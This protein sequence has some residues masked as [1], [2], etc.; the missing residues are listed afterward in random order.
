ATNPPRKD[1]RATSTLTGPMG[2]AA[3]RPRSSPETKMGGCESRMANR[4]RPD[5]FAP[6]RTRQTL[7]M[8][9][10]SLEQAVLVAQDQ[11][12]DMDDVR[13]WAKA[14]LNEQKFSVFRRRLN[15]QR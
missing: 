14:E 9:L 15:R 11:D 12:I 1:R 13:R 5:G 3:P 6:N 4:Y 2:A 8:D 7:L 10:Q